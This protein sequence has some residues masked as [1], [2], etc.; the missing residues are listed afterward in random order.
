MSL[1]KYIR[2][3]FR[4]GTATFKDPKEPQRAMSPLDEN[5]NGVWL[6]DEKYRN[7]SFDELA[8]RCKNLEYYEAERIKEEHS[9]WSRLH[10]AQLE[11]LSLSPGDIIVV[12]HPVPYRYMLEV[13]E[14][15]ET[16]QRQFG[17]S[18]G[19]FL[20][21]PEGMT[22]E[23]IDASHALKCCKDVLQMDITLV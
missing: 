15:V 14:A 19:G 23:A 7:M 10:V 21:L 6:S 17:Y 3:L 20:A 1:L 22:V 16:A 11:K 13:K 8:M 2:N 9:N 5:G 18:W 12:H 4:G